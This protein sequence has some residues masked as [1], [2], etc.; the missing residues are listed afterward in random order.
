MYVYP[1]FCVFCYFKVILAHV[2]YMD[3]GTQENVFISF[4]PLFPANQL[5]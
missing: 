2:D 1:F 4:P 3:L 5:V